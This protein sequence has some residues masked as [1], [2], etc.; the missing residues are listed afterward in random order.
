MD[1]IYIEKYLHPFY[2][3]FQTYIG[4]AHAF[5]TYQMCKNDEIEKHVREIAMHRAQCVYK[6]RWSMVI[7]PLD[8]FVLIEEK[9]TFQIYKKR[10]YR[11][12]T[13]IS[14]SSML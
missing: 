14:F 2:F 7:R 12:L 11:I 1:W 9:V 13:C 5:K 8:G 10:K 6:E 3:I 4:F